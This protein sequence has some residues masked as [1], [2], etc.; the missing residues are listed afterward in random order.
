MPHRTLK[1]IVDR[2]ALVH[3]SA[4]ETVAEAVRRMQQNHVGCALVLDGDE[5]KGIFTGS[6]L[7]GR[8]ID[9]GRDP[10]AVTVGEVMSP[11]PVCLPCSSLGFDAVRQ[12]REYGIRHVVVVRADDGFGVV[13]IHDFPDEELDGYEE[14]MAFEKQLWEE[15]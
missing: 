2:Q 7:V 13:S 5:L 15:M 6:N 9:K 8:V 10:N 12:M 11:N 4:G 1:S 14:E 3:A